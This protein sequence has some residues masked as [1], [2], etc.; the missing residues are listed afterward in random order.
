MENALQK[1]NLQQGH[2]ILMQKEEPKADNAKEAKNSTPASRP[3][4]LL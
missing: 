2:A 1:P 4:L 3:I